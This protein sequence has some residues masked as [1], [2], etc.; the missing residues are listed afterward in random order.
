MGLDIVEL[1][2]AVEDAFQIHIADEEAS[3]ASTVGDLYNLVVAKVQVQDSKRCLTS[4]AFYR[5]RR[6]IVDTLAIDRCKIKPSTPLEVIL[7]R[8]GRRETWRGI[9]TAMKLKLPDLQHT[10]STELSLLA[11]GIVTALAPGIYAR[12]GF[13]SLVCDLSG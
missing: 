4:A 3:T 13:V 10:T 7:P 8:D 12:V 1:I 9:Q 11:I 5:T 6:S 2:L